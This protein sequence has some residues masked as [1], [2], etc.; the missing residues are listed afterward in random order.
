MLI[1]GSLLRQMLS[2]LEV[3]FVS[4]TP[5]QEQANIQDTSS[6]MRSLFHIPMIGTNQVGRP[7][8]SSSEKEGVMNELPNLT[9]HP[10]C[11]KVKLLMLSR[12]GMS[13]LCSLWP[14][15]LTYSGWEGQSAVGFGT[16]S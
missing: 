9:I 1:L 11:P 13:Q 8:E 15:Q 5:G 4:F 7:P 12:L 2:P 10:I 16:G 6:L 3:S 14:T